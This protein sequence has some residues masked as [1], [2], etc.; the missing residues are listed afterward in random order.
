MSIIFVDIKN[1]SRLFN[2][3]LRIKNKLL[4]GIKARASE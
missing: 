1:V 2:K 3:E 4:G